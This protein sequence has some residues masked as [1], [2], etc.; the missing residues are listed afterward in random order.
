MIVMKLGG[1]SAQDAEAIERGTARLN[2]EVLKVKRYL[3]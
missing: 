2:G 1:I 3:I